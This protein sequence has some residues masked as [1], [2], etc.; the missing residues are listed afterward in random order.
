[1]PKLLQINSVVNFRSTGK[2]VEEI[3]NKVISKGWESHVA[4][5]RLARPSQSVLLKIG[6]NWDLIFHGLQNRLLDNQGLASKQATIKFIKQIKVIKPDIIHIHNIHDYYINYEILFNYLITS[7]I[8]IVWTFHDC[9]P[10]TGHCAHFSLIDCDKWKIE[11]YHCPQKKGY[12]TSYFLDRSRRNYQLKKK[13]F[14]SVKNLTIVTVSD[15]LGAIVKESNLSKFPVRVINNGID[16]NTFSPQV[17]S[18]DIRTKYD[19]KD[20]MMLFGAATAWS[21]SKGLKDYYLLSEQLK[22]DTIIVLVGLSANQMKQLP[23]KIIGIPR[24]ENISE[25]VQ[26][27]S[28]ADIVLNLSY[29]ETFGLT[30]VEGLSCGTPGVVYNCTASP[31]LITKETGFIVEPGDINGI[32][33]AVYKIK[34]NGKSFYSN[35]CRARAIQFYDKDQKYQEYINLYNS[36]VK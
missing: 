29:Q 32:L 31:E 27:Y 22:D 24:T 35:A 36:L 8:P 26:L 34:E 17:N 16:I 33:K 5:G 2:I 1:M 23:S 25:L 3:A 30:T 14:N 20:R 7:D 19:I 10:I 6:N 21:E 11:C 12:P 18:R 28:A 15:W 4:Y 13:L 9:W